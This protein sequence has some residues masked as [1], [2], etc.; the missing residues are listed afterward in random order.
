MTVMVIRCWCW[1]NQ[2]VQPV[3][4]GKIRAFIGSIVE[5]SVNVLSHQT[6]PLGEPILV[7]KYNF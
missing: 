6:A 5:K 4:R 3:T 2:P 1:L 7:V